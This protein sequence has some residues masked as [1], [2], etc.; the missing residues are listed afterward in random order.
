MKKYN[1][2]QEGRAQQIK[3]KYNG[4]NR[5]D[6]MLEVEVSRSQFYRIIKGS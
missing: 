3:T 4:R 1:I 5:K 6:L 2:D